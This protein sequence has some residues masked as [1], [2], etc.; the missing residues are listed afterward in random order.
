MWFIAV[1]QPSPLFPNCR[2]AILRDVERELY[3]PI[4]N[5]E[6]FIYSIKVVWENILFGLRR[7]RRIV[8]D[9][10]KNVLN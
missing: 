4:K 1:P 7:E 10:L 8:E 5:N 9:L 6:K 2:Y 3:A